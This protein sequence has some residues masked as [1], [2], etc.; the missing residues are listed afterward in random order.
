MVCCALP[1]PLHAPRRP[2]T[3]PLEAGQLVD[4]L[5]LQVPPPSHSGERGKDGTSNIRRVPNRGYSQVEA[6]HGHPDYTCIYRVMVHGQV[7]EEVQEEVHEEVH[8][9]VQEEVVR[10]EEVQ[11]EEV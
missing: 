5:T 6:N 8:E 9:V 10:G 1:S 4:T 7:Q 3:F 2:L 11:G